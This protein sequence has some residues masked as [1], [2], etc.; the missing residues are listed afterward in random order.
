MSRNLWRVVSLLAFN[1][2]SWSQPY[3]ISTVAGTARLVPGSMANATPL[4]DPRS[5]ALDAGG[6]LYIADTADNRVLKVGA[7]GVVSILAGNG[8]P[9]FSGDRGKAT[10]ASLFSPTGVAIDNSGNVYVADRDNFR[11]RRISPDGTINTVAGNGTR[12]FSGD[13][14]P[15]TRAQLVPLAVAVDSA[16]ALYISDFI[17]ARI[18]KVDMNGI[19]TTIAGTGSPGT[20]GD[21]G[22][23]VSAQIGLVTGMAVDSSGTLYLADLPN[24]RVR[25]IDA[26][27]MITTIA[28]SGFSGFIDDGVKATDSLM[29]PDGVALDGRGSLYLSDLNLDVVRKVDLST[30]LITT[31]AGNAAN[32]FSGDNGPALQAELN[33]PAGLAFDSLAGSI[34][35]A[36]R[37]NARVR[38]VALAM[39]TTFAG[40]DIRN[41]GPATSA[42]LNFPLGL[43]A[44]AGN[45]VVVADSGNAATRRFTSGGTIG[46]IGQVDGVPLGVASDPAGNV[47]VTDDEPLV[48]KISPG[49]VTTIVAGNRK[50]GYAGDGGQAINA[51]I[52]NPT[53]V[54]VDAGGNVFFTDFTNN[55]IRKVTA[56]TGA[57]ATIAG[58]GSF[59]FSG[60][61]GPA[62]SAGMDPFDIAIDSR[63]NLYVADRF[64]NRIRKI[65]PDGTISTIAGTGAFGYSGDGG[66]ATNA[67]LQSPSGIAVDAAGNIFITDHGN[68]VV[69]RITPSGLITTIAGSGTFTP[70]AGD[71]GLANSAQLDPVRI[72]ADSSGNLYVTDTFN[73]RVRKL[74]P[75]AV[76]PAAIKIVSGDNQTAI[77]GAS[78][79]APLVIQVTDNT[80][81]AVPGVVVTF[82]AS[83]AG[84]ATFTLTNAITLPDGTASTKVTLSSA[85]GPVSIN[86]TSAGVPGVSFSVTSAAAVSPTAPKIASGGVVGAG[87]SNPAV[88]AVSPNGIAT[89]FGEK[90]AP[91]G[92]AKQVSTDDLVNG[93]IP[94]SLSGVC[95]LVGNQRAPV[96][97]VFPGQLNIQVPQ[98]APGNTGVQVIA[99]CDTPQAERSNVEMVTIQ[100]ASPEFFYFL[101]SADGH[102]PIAALNAVTGGYIGSP[103][104]LAGLSFT[105]AKSG[106]ILTLFATGL[107]ATD[108]AFAPGELPGGAAQV[109]GTVGIT[110]GKVPLDAADI[111]YVGVTQNAGLYQV[112]LRVP[113]GVPD[114]DD[115]VVIQIGGAA[116]PANAYITVRNASE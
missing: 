47:Y 80:G 45:Q 40:A 12:G 23:A 60:D 7:T 81:A 25:K 38:K 65:A 10:S 30:N 87:L 42:F 97:T 9:A 15:A 49:G 91:S 102:N 50:D 105:P 100:P 34:F 31:V 32:G 70:S 111:L 69:R 55:R 75:K 110:I 88:K 4:R 24:L 19:I 78:L 5:V 108:P 56:A 64:N 104:L 28:G 35:I 67:L 71:G 20:S 43:T 106:D 21:N 2:I 112:N 113:A 79:S 74:T 107:G 92:T 37:G 46:P 62:L 101:Q 57:I 76:T 11:V 94:T 54:A 84:S 72:A 90:F 44:L 41:N 85:V 109:T 39:I 17:N 22:P 89:I 29:V 82:S 73:D 13:G 6:N 18:R 58:N 8:V 59:T 66:L 86:V 33:G 116:S 61:N 77:A 114:G 48:L 95:V 27:G 115:S 52:S 36:D 83:P 93:R 98:L 26:S 51:Q 68:A 1:V 16:G 14:G 63:S 3:V 96:L 99:N 103:G 53:G